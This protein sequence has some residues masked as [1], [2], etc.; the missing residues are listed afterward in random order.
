MDRSGMRVIALLALLAT[1]CG[2]GPPSALGGDPSAGKLLL[3]QYGCAGCHRIPGVPAAYGN[4]GP[5]L[6]A[7]ARRVYLAGRLPNTPEN[8]AAWI[9]D[10]QRIDPRTLMPDMQLSEAQAR[11]IVAY[12]YTLR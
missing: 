11:D 4:T 3:R 12:L 1:A 7:L 8:L 6:D 9:R 5:P 2:A 10:P